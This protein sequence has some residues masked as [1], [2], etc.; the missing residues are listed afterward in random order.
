MIK[1]WG[2]TAEK[3]DRVN[4]YADWQMMEKV[5]LGNRINKILMASYKNISVKNKEL[6]GITKVAN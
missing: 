3:I 2:W 1:E 5:E 6:E 4:Q